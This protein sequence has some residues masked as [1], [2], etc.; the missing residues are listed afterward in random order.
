MLL[1]KRVKCNKNYYYF[2]LF[3]LFFLRLVCMQ[4]RLVG[5]FFTRDSSKNVKSRKDVPIWV[6]K[7]KFNIK[8]PIHSQKPLKFASKRTCS[9]GNT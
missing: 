2:Y 7:L 3:V 5:E 4:V 6:I 8:P 9:P 1:G